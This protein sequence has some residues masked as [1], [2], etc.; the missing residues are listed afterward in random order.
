MTFRQAVEK[1]PDLQGA[2]RKGLGA[3]RARDSRHI[4]AE[5]TRRLTGSVD[6]DTALKATQPNANRWDF[7]IGYRH[8]N[9]RYEFIYW[10]E[11]HTASDAQVNVV[12]KKLDWLFQWLRS[13]GNALAGF[14]GDF[15]WVASGATSF[16][17]GATQRRMM[18]EKGLRYESRILHIPDKNPHHTA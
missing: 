1:T 18:A 10:V 9:R 16:T 8:S 12:L 13:S 4:S 11:T 6:V 15:V 5:D 3:L 17:K 7:A 14:E 2:W